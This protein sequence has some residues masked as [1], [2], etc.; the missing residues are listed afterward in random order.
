MISKFLFKLTNFCVIVCFFTKLL[1]L[2]ILFSPA[3]N[4]FVAAKLITSGILFSNSV[5][6]IF[7]NKIS[8]IGD[9]FSNSAL[10]VRYL[11][12]ETKALVSM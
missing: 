5:S 4:T 11:V 2:A 12:F 1:T 6:F 9:F 7:F 3:L 8:H 10:S